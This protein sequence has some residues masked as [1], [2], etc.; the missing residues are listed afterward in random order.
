MDMDQQQ[1]YYYYC[2]CYMMW[3]HRALA[4]LILMVAIWWRDS[5]GRR[6]R[7]RGA[8]YG[9]LVDRDISRTNTLARLIDA[10]DATCIKQLRMSRPVFHKLC[11]RLKE[12][13]L[14]VDTFHVSVEE[15]VA[16]FLYMVGQHH[17]NASVGFSF[18]RSGETVS[19]YFNA[20]LQA[21]GQLARDLIYV[22]STDT[23]TKITSS[24]NRFYPYF[25]GCIGALDGTHIRACVPANMVDRFRGR[26]SYPSQNVLAVVDFDLRFTYVLAG[27]EGSAHDSLV[28]QDAL[29]RPA[30]LKIPEG[31]F[32]LADAGYAARPG[33]LPPYR[34][35]RY[36]LNEFAESRE[37]NTPKE[38]FNHR[39]SSLRTTVER[40]FGTL[41]NRFKILSHKPFIPLKSQIKVV[42]AC[43]ALHNWILEN[44]PDEYVWD[45]STW[46]S[47]LPRSSGRVRDRDAD[48]REWAA[49]RDLL[50][51]QMWDERERNIASGSTA[52]V[53][54]TTDV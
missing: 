19:R 34:G 9:P 41:K 50:A 35:V 1:Y 53:T 23:H 38:L 5:D 54:R 25:K 46:Y 40:A 22:K 44:G 11:S 8:K 47:H 52:V 43:C 17:T 49:K 18:W 30:G 2:M 33:I 48:V 14:L 12:R 42:V 39:H 4:V 20:V 32:Y 26:K 7:G 21:M 13:G 51:Q 24:P 31:K 3:R 27:W 15:Q 6:S 37:P 45:E 36:H 10:S 28:L 16:I 29:S